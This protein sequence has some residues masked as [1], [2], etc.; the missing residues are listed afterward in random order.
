MNPQV[1]PAIVAFLVLT[2]LTG[3]AYPLVVA[4]LAWA[5]FPRQAAGSLLRHDGRAVG[6]RLI[7]QVFSDPGDFWGRP[8][9]TVGADGKPRPCDGANSGG[10]NLS[11]GNPQLRQAVAARVAALQAAD[12]GQGPVPVDLVT[13]SG[14]G[15]DPHISPAAAAFQAHRVAR[16][17]GLD[18]ARVRALVAAGTERPQ[19]GFLGE[20]RVNV[21]DL[22]LALDALSGK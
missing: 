18:E 14:S 9:A 2:A 13:A 8:S 6:S 22:N 16:A 20:A 5:A 11:P 4:G 15:L 7:G 12:P 10:S 19:L 17:R 1:R 21:L 3:G